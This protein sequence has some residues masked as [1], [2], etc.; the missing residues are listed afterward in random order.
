LAAWRINRAVDRR[1]VL[2]TA[3]AVD[4]QVEGHNTP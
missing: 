4:Q 3:A 1:T 2:A